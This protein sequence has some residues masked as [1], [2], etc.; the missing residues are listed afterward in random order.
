MDIKIEFRNLTTLPNVNE[1]IEIANDAL[2]TEKKQNL[3]VEN[4]NNNVNLQN[5]TYESKFP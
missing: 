3:N 2:K 5:I 1:V 4:L